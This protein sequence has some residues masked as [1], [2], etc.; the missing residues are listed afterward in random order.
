[1]SPVNP[2]NGCTIALTPGE[3]A[4]A[5]CLMQLYSNARAQGSSE[6]DRLAW[7]F[8]LL[9]AATLAKGMLDPEQGKNETCSGAPTRELPEEVKDELRAGTAFTPAGPSLTSVGYAV[10][11]IEDDDWGTGTRPR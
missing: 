7:Q 3:C 10:H 9:F 1:M 2:T 4:S 11:A 6:N 8:A 5:V